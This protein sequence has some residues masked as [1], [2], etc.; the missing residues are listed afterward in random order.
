VDYEHLKDIS[1]WVAFLITI[2]YGGRAFMALA[3]EFK[4]EIVLQL[5]ELN[6]SVRGQDTKINKMAESIRRIEEKVNP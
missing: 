5:K 2:W 3:R 1:G 6:K 4:N